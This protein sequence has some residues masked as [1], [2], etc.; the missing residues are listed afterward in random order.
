MQLARGSSSRVTGL[1][2]ETTQFMRS[3][4]PQEGFPHY[5]PQ[6]SQQTVGSEHSRNFQ[7]FHP[8]GGEQNRVS[9][10]FPDANMQYHGSS[11]VPPRIGDAS[12]ASWKSEALST[13]VPPPRGL[14]PPVNV[15]KAPPMH[16]PLPLH[17]QST[18]HFDPRNA[19]NTVSN[20]GPN[21]SFLGE[22]Q[23]NSIGNKAI[24]STKLFSFPN[25]QTVPTLSSPQNPE[26]VPSGQ[27]QLP[28]SQEIRRNFIPPATFLSMGPMPSYVPQVGHGYNPALNN[29]MSNP[30]PGVHSSMPILNTPSNSLYFQSGPGFPPLPAGLRPNSSQM[31][32]L[33]QNP[34][35]IGPSPQ[36]GG[37]LSGLI[38]SLMA[39]GLISLTQQAPVQVSFWI[40]FLCGPF[41]CQDYIIGLDY[42]SNG[43]IYL[44]FGWNFCSWH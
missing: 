18:S 12:I 33:S 5:V 13:Y 22:H 36:A 24:S 19:S 8:S 14:W 29:V 10:S 17:N 1:H 20:Q 9:S 7:M 21:K 27:P 11:V 39:Q 37:A 4:Y 28:V 42:I 26:Q 44:M 41:F 3:R 23:F 43:T 40:L 30:I 31:T 34:V 32:P 2:D 6:S 25:Q 15:Q 16:P 38:S 35:P